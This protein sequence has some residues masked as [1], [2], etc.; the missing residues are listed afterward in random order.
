MQGAKALLEKAQ[1]E[2]G[3]GL[4]ES[5]DIFNKRS[6]MYTTLQSPGDEDG[7]MFGMLPKPSIGGLFNKKM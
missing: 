4:W 6:F 1:E 7:G 5:M 3:Q 2:K